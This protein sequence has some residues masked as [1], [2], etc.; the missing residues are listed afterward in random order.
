MN[1]IDTSTPLGVALALLPEIVVS[2]VT[3]VRKAPTLPK[4]V[5]PG[6]ASQPARRS[7]P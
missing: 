3:S 5:R 4:S 1:P 7:T 6:V 2:V